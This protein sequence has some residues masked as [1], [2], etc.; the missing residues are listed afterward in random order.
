MEPAWLT[1]REVAKLLQIGE[2]STARLIRNGTIPSIQIGRTRRVPRLDF[3]HFLAAF[4]RTEKAAVDGLEDLFTAKKP[5]ATFTPEPKPT[6][7]PGSEMPHDQPSRRT[8][9]RA[10]RTSGV[11]S[12]SKGSRRPPV[13]LS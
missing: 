12:N 1:T 11:S 8:T 4:P 13:L 5:G 9:R 6:A 10:G 3:E 2:S 7:A